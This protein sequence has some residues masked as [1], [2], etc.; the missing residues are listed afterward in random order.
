MKHKEMNLLLSFISI[1]ISTFLIWNGSKWISEYFVTRYDIFEKPV[2][3]LTFMT[4]SLVLYTA[5]ITVGE[6]LLLEKLFAIQFDNASFASSVIISSLI[7]LFITTVHASY[8]FFIQWKENRIKAEQLEKAGL[9]ARYG[10]LREQLN[11]HFLFNS[12]NTLVMMVEDNA[13][14]TRYVESLSD[15]LRYGLQN[16]DKEVISLR[17]EMAIARHYLFIQQR[18]FGDKLRIT[19]DVPEAYYQFAIPP[20]SLQ[21]LL[22]NALKHN[23]VSKEKNLYIDIQVTPDRYLVVTNPIQP[24]TDIEAST[25]IGLANIDNRYRLLGENQVVVSTENGLFKVKLPL[26][27]VIK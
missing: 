25:G 19:I 3:L 11:P 10:M 12:L 23:I 13:E 15:I 26:L 18:R 17:D 2:Q 27:E 16:R 24:K 22:E 5:A 7:T 9:E 21:I 8:Y 20:M 1:I 4:L 14:A 6:M